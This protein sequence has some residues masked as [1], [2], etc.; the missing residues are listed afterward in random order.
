MHLKGVSR[1]AA[2]LFLSFAEPREVDADDDLIDLVLDG[3]LEVEH[4]D[5][6]LSGADA[7]PFMCASMSPIECDDLSRDALVHAQDLETSDT[8]ALAQS[9]YLFNRIPLT[10]FW[11]S[12]FPD[13]PAILDHL[14]T[15]RA[16]LKNLLEKTWRVSLDQRHWVSWFSRSRRSHRNDEVTYKLYVSPRPEFLREAF[17]I[18]VR[19]LADFPDAGFKIGNSA[20][21]LLRPDKLI[22]YFLS[23]EEMAEAG[24]RLARELAGCDPHGVPF[25]AKIDERGLISWGIDPP[26]DDVALRWIGRRSWRQWVVE[27]LA[28]AIAVAKWARTPAAVEPWRFSLERAARSGIEVETW[29]PREALW[30]RA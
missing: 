21:D 3:V 25:T 20:A 1:N 24:A 6:F 19:V 10:P 17:E 28:A 12:R 8:S 11:R 30:S 2:D 7:L 18:V 29:T 14:G 9:L 13:R 4:G 15:A 22:V 26:D 16:P 23:S 27:R 5:D